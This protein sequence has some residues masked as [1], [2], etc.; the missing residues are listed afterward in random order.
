MV[1]NP[2]YHQTLWYTFLMVLWNGVWFRFAMFFRSAAIVQLGS[3]E[4]ALRQDFIYIFT[5]WKVL[6][7]QLD[8][9]EAY[10]QPINLYMNHFYIYLLTPVDWGFM[11]LSMNHSFVLVDLGY[12]CHSPTGALWN[13]CNR[14]RHKRCQGCIGVQVKEE[15]PRNRSWM[16]QSLEDITQVSGKLTW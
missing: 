6:F 14:C 1:Y 7:C 5:V 2:K 15:V 8:C 13:T 4:M 10:E 16:I 11:N 3:R 12:T 9:M